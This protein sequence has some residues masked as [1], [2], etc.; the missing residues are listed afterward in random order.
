LFQ[1]FQGCALDNL[2]PFCQLDLMDLAPATK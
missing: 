2:A 1:I